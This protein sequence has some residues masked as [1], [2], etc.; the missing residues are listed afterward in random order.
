M[1]P[2]KKTLDVGK[3]DRVIALSTDDTLSS[4]EITI[5]S[6][7]DDT[8]AATG[9]DPNQR[10][11]SLRLD[12][13]KE[14]VYASKN[15]LLTLASSLSS[16]ASSTIGTKMEEEERQET[17]AARY[18]KLLQVI[19][20]YE[21]APAEVR[22][23]VANDVNKAIDA[24]N[25]EQ[26]SIDKAYTLSAEEEAFVDRVKHIQYLSSTA[27]AELTDAF[28]QYKAMSPEAQQ[29][30]LPTVQNVY[31]SYMAF[32]RYE[33]EHAAV[34]DAYR[35][36]PKSFEHNITFS[37]D[38]LQY[39]GLTDEEATL[40]H[41][42]N[43]LN[44][45]EMSRDAV[46]KEISAY[47]NLDSLSQTRL[48]G[49][50]ERIVAG[51][52][53]VHPE[54]A[55]ML[56][57]LQEQ[58]LSNYSS[59]E[60]NRS[61]TAIR[62][63]LER[64]NADTMSYESLVNTAKV[65]DR[66]PDSS[67]ATLYGDYQELV[68]RYNQAHPQ[69]ESYNGLKE[70]LIQSV[71]ADYVQPSE[72][73]ATQQSLHDSLAKI[74]PETM[75]YESLDR[76]MT[77]YGRFGAE[78]KIA[79]Y[80]DYERLVSGYVAAHPRSENAETLQAILREDYVNAVTHR[81]QEL[82][83]DEIA[84]RDHMQSIK[85]GAMSYESLTEAV[86]G[87]DNLSPAA[88]AALYDTYSS[89]VT[90]YETAHPLDRTPE[91]IVPAMRETLMEKFQPA[92][93]NAE[94]YELRAQVAA[95]DVSKM[96]F[97][98]LES[99]VH[100]LYNASDATRNALY[101]DYATLIENY[102]AAHPRKAN[103]AMELGQEMRNYQ[104]ELADNKQTHAILE[105]CRTLYD[106]TTIVSREANI[107]VANRILDTYATL[108]VSDREA[109]RGVV[110]ES[111]EHFN[112]FEL[113]RVARPME[114]DPIEATSQRYSPA[115]YE[116]KDELVSYGGDMDLGQRAREELTFV[117]QKQLMSL[118]AAR[119]NPEFIAP[120][121]QEVNTVGMLRET[122]DR[123]PDGNIIP[124]TDAAMEQYAAAFTSLSP[125]NRELVLH[126]FV[127]KYNASSHS[128]ELL[129]KLDK[130]DGFGA[131]LEGAMADGTK[132]MTTKQYESTLEM[133]G[134][135]PPNIS[136][137]ID[138]SSVAYNTWQTY[139][140]EHLTN[141]S[142][143]EAINT[144]FENSKVFETADFGSGFGPLAS[145]KVA[146]AEIHEFAAQVDSFKKEQMLE[147]FDKFEQNKAAD[148]YTAAD[149][150]RAFS[151]FSDAH[152]RWAAS[153]EIQERHAALVES[154]SAYA[155]ATGAEFARSLE[156]NPPATAAAMKKQIAEF[157][158]LPFEAKEHALGALTTA[159]VAYEDHSKTL[160]LNE[161]FEKLGQVAMQPQVYGDIMSQFESPARAVQEFR[162]LPVERQEEIYNFALDRC[163]QTGIIAS[164]AEVPSADEDI[165]VRFSTL[166]VK[167][168]EASE[169]KNQV[170]ND[171]VAENFD[172]TRSGPIM[173]QYAELS[174]DKKVELYEEL[175]SRVV[176]ADLDTRVIAGN[177]KTVD[178][179]TE[180]RTH[181]TVET[182]FEQT[183]GKY[184]EECFDRGLIKEQ[185]MVESRLALSIGTDTNKLPYIEEH[186]NAPEN[187]PTASS[188][189][190]AA[191]IVRTSMS[192]EIE[193]EKAAAEFKTD[194][195]DLSYAVSHR[196]QIVY[197]RTT[198][199]LARAADNFNGPGISEGAR[200]YLAVTYM[201]K[202]EGFY[203]S[204]ATENQVYYGG[205]VAGDNNNE[206]IQLQIDGLVG[207]NC[208]IGH[209]PGMEDQR[210]LVMTNE[211][212]DIGVTR[213]NRDMY[214]AL[215]GIPIINSTEALDNAAKFSF[216]ENNRCIMDIPVP[217][218]GSMENYQ[219]ASENV[220]QQFEVLNVVSDG[221]NGSVLTVRNMETDQVMDIATSI[222]QKDIINA[223]Q[224]DVE[225]SG[226]KVLIHNVREPSPI[227]MDGLTD[228]H[229]MA[230]RRDALQAVMV[231]DK[232][233]E[234]EA[235]GT[236]TPDKFIYTD[237]ANIV[238]G[239][240]TMPVE[241]FTYN[242]ETNQTLVGYKDGDE[243][244]YTLV[245]KPLAEISSE[246]F[247]R[248]PDVTITSE[249]T[250]MTTINKF[251]VLQY[252]HDSDLKFSTIRD[253]SEK[254][255]KAVFSVYDSD[256]QIVK[257][258]SEL[259]FAQASSAFENCMRRSAAIDS[260]EIPSEQITFRKGSEH[261]Y[262]GAGVG[263]DRIFG[264][265]VSMTDDS[266]TIRDA[267][268]G[269]ITV[270]A[271]EGNLIDTLTKGDSVVVIRNDSEL[272]IGNGS[273]AQNIFNPDYAKDNSMSV[274]VVETTKEK[275]ME[276]EFTLEHLGD[277][278][279]TSQTI[280]GKVVHGNI[281]YM[282]AEMTDDNTIKMTIVE[283]VGQ[284]MTAYQIEGISHSE[285]KEFAE[286]TKLHE[287]N[288]PELRDALQRMQSS[289][290]P[291]VEDVTRVVAAFN[292]IQSD[293]IAVD[294]LKYQ[295]QE[296]DLIRASIIE[297][298]GQ[299]L[300]HAYDHEGRSHTFRDPVIKT[301]NGEMFAYVSGE[302]KFEKGENGKRQLVVSD[303]EN[304]TDRYRIVSCAFG[305]FNTL[306]QE[307]QKE[308]NWADI[309]ERKEN[310]FFQNVNV[311]YTV[312]THLNSGG[313]DMRALFDERIGVS[314]E[315]TE[316]HRISAS[317]IQIDDDTKVALNYGVLIQDA[318]DGPHFTY[319][320]PSQESTLFN[321]TTTDAATKYLPPE[322]IPTNAEEAQKGN[323][324]LVD[325][326]HC[327]AIKQGGLCYRLSEDD[328]NKA[329]A[330]SGRPQNYYSQTIAEPLASL[331]QH[332]QF[333][334]SERFAGATNDLQPS[335]N[336]WSINVSA[337]G[338]PMLSF[339]EASAST[340]TSTIG[341]SYEIKGITVEKDGT[342]IYAEL[343]TPIANADNSTGS[344]SRVRL[345]MPTEQ[346]FDTMEK[347]TARTIGDAGTKM[348]H[349]FEQI[350]DLTKG[351]EKQVDTSKLE[352]GKYVV[353]Q[354]EADKPGV[355]YKVI[356]EKSLMIVGGSDDT[357]SHPTVLKGDAI[358]GKIITQIDDISMQAQSQLRFENHTVYAEFNKDTSG[359]ITGVTIGDRAVLNDDKGSEKVDGNTFT[360]KA[361][362][363]DRTEVAAVHDGDEISF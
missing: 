184:L 80:G 38:H 106:N 315:T 228:E 156:E 256:G 122:L 98:Q 123:T 168:F 281:A 235:I 164:S 275:F 355:V 224:P 329:F 100:D 293:V 306:S 137:S 22:Y 351:I 158:N 347:A 204:G 189:V 283:Q 291:A 260:V 247:M 243:T 61:E 18:E 105:D 155:A 307:T 91:T 238:I 12:E 200:E 162:N 250:Q 331:E 54:L 262:A 271:T 59:S 207:P 120:I 76:M 35:E 163:R 51:Y 343:V 139:V 237:K 8:V 36:L 268:R 333:V 231:P 297:R 337:S 148:A 170:F 128:P 362:E 311:E 151:E 147:L 5:R 336:N 78:D 349:Y 109:V 55:D 222:K 53:S 272:T 47:S 303:S 179:A 49:D 323:F 169:N 339:E 27:S 166:M 21:R 319:F 308:F 361:H 126:D 227:E 296:G 285:I 195:K 335:V 338:K 167:S 32:N 178:G 242:I 341:R 112:G 101:N 312:D 11:E 87:F 230:F 132:G 50:Y 274:S 115:Y 358:N 81:P 287:I 202:V 288:D 71:V 46:E 116:I 363:V 173:L 64:L 29:A 302:Q 172:T 188:I 251:V 177:V 26:A 295:P 278:L 232:V 130:I 346:Q 165:S 117:E 14:D 77:T 88:K 187:Q 85:P 196:N 45:Q 344:V 74:N 16:R 67:K 2:S 23:V 279:T 9:Y 86:A 4:H 270:N 194:C 345:C 84:L 342:G 43:A 310:S 44:P 124:V 280:D 309:I 292:E 201:N 206:R 301:E 218:N 209:V 193:R 73:T 248:E 152:P 330:E 30:I 304:G 60:L 33:D 57:G 203:N 267:A 266:V 175:A 140:D 24:M 286:L 334:S 104:M 229:A 325:Y 215:S 153:P 282:H 110:L 276:R 245:N 79:L 277:E 93:Y 298:D 69:V 239:D 197:A 183:T 52:V 72:L 261:I 113:E 40:R 213:D 258:E 108:S 186:R 300:L 199:D 324:V 332:A 96:S 223:V 141:A 10:Y 28:E 305:E 357:A 146:I 6:L 3:I 314:C 328:L 99:A 353:V 144:T 41:T 131:A 159:Y 31:N 269:L 299:L 257:V 68:D 352:R 103:E 65:F 118:A 121:Q 254:D 89:T 265:V 350:N 1:K 192:E 289:T 241:S 20:E 217:V 240:K 249:N 34:S 149:V 214:S 82:T 37:V 135:L 48:Y 185:P 150:A 246:M 320:N 7:A 219:P 136:A 134:N 83:A 190:A 62:E 125:Q 290:T 13:D 327:V 90:G 63:S 181:S 157:D 154:S 107:E 226:N 294:S 321:V 111:V 316:N 97:A 129:A 359:K 216:D 119:E 212:I 284:N 56:V 360:C 176:E 264:Q 244:K 102:A 210:I 182:Q 211:P 70:S 225:I 221:I 145:E 340:S 114:R 317:H 142:R 42:L 127:E 354:D 252:E 205:F 255:G 220:R 234:P 171:F 273:E 66:L 94:E 326:E 160:T 143:V 92:L 75:S 17:M 348:Q 25:Q 259:T 15:D 236:E 39:I 208:F 95:Y 138:A 191:N 133:L 263:E 180:I 322:Q 356:T 161:Q 233:V 174:Y 318:K 253:I 198:D 19:H 313:R 58:Y